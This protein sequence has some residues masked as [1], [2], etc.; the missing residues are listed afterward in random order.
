MPVWDLTTRNNWELLLTERR[1]VT[2]NNNT[3]PNDLQY[4]YTPIP[5]IYVAPDYHT[6]L[7]GTASNSVK[8]HWFLGAIASQ[9]LYVSPSGNFSTTSGVQ[10]SDQK[11]IGLNRLTLVEFKNYNVSPYVLQLEIPYWI[12]DIYIEIWEYTGYI[13]Q[14]Y[15]GQNYQELLGRLDSIED[16]LNTIE[17]YGI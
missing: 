8:A 7:I 10:V 17:Y 4:K 13:D 6:L 9:Y 11:K 12:E 2:Y 1:A 15:E 14:T 3:S 5:P 16:K